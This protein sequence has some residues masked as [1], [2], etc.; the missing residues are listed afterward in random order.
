L[1]VYAIYDAANNP[2]LG[3]LSDRTKTRWGR[4]IPYIMFGAAPYA[5]VFAL[6]WM[7]PFDGISHA[8]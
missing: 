6:L 1:F 5:L 4:R 3:Y 2:V 8:R 7:A